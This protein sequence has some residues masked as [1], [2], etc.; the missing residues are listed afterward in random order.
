MK[1]VTLKIQGMHC[2][3]CAETL[4]A[5]L[6]REPG[7]KTVSVTFGNGEARVLYDPGAVDEERLVAAAQRP[8][9]R[10]VSRAP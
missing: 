6:E 1:S 2:D 8:G 5:L 3:G 7:V 4:K 9:Y 10:V